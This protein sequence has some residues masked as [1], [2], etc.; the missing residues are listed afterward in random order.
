MRKN[1]GFAQLL[2]IISLIVV[3]SFVLIFGSRLPFI[4]SLGFS[5]AS[6]TVNGTVLRMIVDGLPGKTHRDFSGVQLDSGQ[7]I[8][9]PETSISKIPSGT[10]ISFSYPTTS[11]S[12]QK[13]GDYNL[14][15]PTNV[16]VV[17]SVRP[18]NTFL[19]TR[20]VAV[21]LTQF[22]DSNPAALPNIT[23]T[24]AESLMNGLVKSFYDENSFKTS[25]LAP[26]LTFTSTS[27]NG[28][29]GSGNTSNR[30]VIPMSQNDYNACDLVAVA[31]AAIRH[32][33]DEVDSAHQ[34]DLRNYDHLVLVYPGNCGYSGMAS[35]GGKIS[36]PTLSFG[37]VQ[38][39]IVGIPDSFF[40]TNSYGSIT[41]ELGHNLGAVHSQGYDCG[42]RMFDDPSNCSVVDYG[43]PFDDMGAATYH[44]NNYIK[45]HLGWLD[46]G[47]VLQ[48][49]ST[50][51][52]T[53]QPIEIR[54][55]QP[56][57]LKIK[58]KT[59]TDGTEDWFYVENRIATGIDSSMSS[60][61]TSGALIRYVNG[62]LT[63]TQ[64]AFRSTLLIDSTPNSQSGGGD[65]NDAG[66]PINRTFTDSTTG[67]SI[68][69]TAKSG[70]NL[71]LHVVVPGGSTPAPTVDL[72]INGGNGPITVSQGSTLSLSWTST[73][74]TSCTASGLWT[75]TK[76]INGSLSVP[77]VTSSG[78]YTLTCSGA[79]GNS[80]D[81][82][83]VTVTSA[84]YDAA[85]CWDMSGQERGVMYWSDVC[86]GIFSLYK[87]PTAKGQLL[88]CSKT[89][90]TTPTLVSLKFTS[91]ELTGYNAWVSAG[92]PA[93]PCS[94]YP[95][96][97][98]G[99]NLQ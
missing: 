30:Y 22:Q 57:L 79:G 49:T 81:S 43:D 56:Q 97:R 59:N 53:I 44:F 83:S 54:T 77:S 65:F 28:G 38:I 88:T 62:E 70:N 91:S 27:F 94:P 82:V 9:V 14:V 55:T 99:G 69:P 23:K 47:N 64:A 26:K 45:E 12:I 21:V 93:T 6:T 36:V 10:R 75:G 13:I 29:E 5:R 67:I 95:A 3:A 39:Y 58:R 46:A 19:G 96:L 34:I 41:H 8:L 66:F 61:G 85:R 98:G 80:S 76:V 84:T 18:T 24:S 35:V 72:K 15:S 25:T 40:N 87:V 51:D 33:S 4:Q 2:L 48:V 73:N 16:S 50:G 37:A 52:Y 20:K 89:F 7:Y 17:G 86:K 42:S 32:I 68:T 92:K 78:T 63:T 11:V 1:S 60:Y 71:T 31:N 74:A 90:N